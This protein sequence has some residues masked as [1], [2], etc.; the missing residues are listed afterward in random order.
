MMDETWNSL[1]RLIKNE[2]M[3]LLKVSKKKA[4][5]QKE[6]GV[7]DNIKDKHPYVRRNSLSYF[8]S[9]LKCLLRHVGQVINKRTK[10]QWCGL[11]AY[12]ICV[13]YCRLQISHQDD[14]GDASDLS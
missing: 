8:P 12:Q 2:P 7:T 14:K 6:E 4:K 10:R 13:S 11:G 5:K 1:Q 9:Q 3:L